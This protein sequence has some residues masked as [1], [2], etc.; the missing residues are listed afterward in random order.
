[1]IKKLRMR[2]RVMMKNKSFSILLIGAIGLI[3]LSGCQADQTPE[4]A[5]LA[6]IAEHPINQINLSGPVASSQAEVS[7]MAWCGDQLI[8]L[9]QFP[10]QFQTDGVGRVFSID[11]ATLSAYLD[12]A[13][14]AA[15]EPEQIVFDTAGLPKALS[16]FEGFEAIAFDQDTVYV[17]VETRQSDGMLGYI[18]KGAV[19]GDCSEIVL[20]PESRQ[21]IPPQ[22]DLSN[23]TDE[24]IV[25]FGQQVYTFYEANGINVNPKPVAHVFDLDLIP[26]G[27]VEFPSIEYRVTDATVTA[28]DGSFWAI[29]YFYPGDTKLKPG[30]D[31]IALSYGIGQTHQTAEQVER[32]VEMQ[33]TPSGIILLDVAPIYL[34]LDSEESSNWEGL[35]RMGEGFL[36]VTDEYPTT[37]LG[38]VSGVKE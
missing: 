25:I 16:G 12:G 30:D 32:I 9:P 34:Q 1:M 21:E 37:I 2:A 4:A 31:Q 5:R 13:S 18:L 33:V 24:T 7:G 15:I 6:T 28:G 10:D 22:A 36:M 8:L 19:S 11:K 35:V 14:T 3:L 26:Q 27:T 20:D 29:N 23:M 38:Y 17:T